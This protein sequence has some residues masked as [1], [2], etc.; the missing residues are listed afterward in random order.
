VVLGLG[1]CAAV[2]MIATEFSTIQSVRVGDSTC[3]VFETQQQQDDCALTG[4]EQ[5]AYA[6]V[7]LGLFTA[8]L[9]FGAGAGRSRPA[10]FALIFVGLVV[11]FIALVLDRPTLDDVRGFDVFSRAEG[12]A[13]G[14]YTLELI[15]GALALLAGVVALVFDR[16]E[17]RR[18]RADDGD[19]RRSRRRSSSGEPAEQQ[20]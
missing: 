3:G 1:L 2:L 19:A 6:L 18:A 10:A 20:Q 15:G 4:G 11:L 17:A 14:A 9:A 5:H 13:G 7:L 12:E 16:V 8:M